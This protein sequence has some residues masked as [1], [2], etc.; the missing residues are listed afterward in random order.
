[1]KNARSAPERKTFYITQYALTKGILVGQGRLCES[2][3]SDGVLLDD[4]GG[5]MVSVIWPGGLNGEALFHKPD[6]HDTLEAAQERVAKMVAA[7]LAT[8]DKQRAALL[9]M[10]Q[11]GA[12]VKEI[13]K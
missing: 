2:R 7:K 4:Y 10:Q 11:H 1:M 8:I 5:R 13:G 6:W 12:S 9:Q 3:R